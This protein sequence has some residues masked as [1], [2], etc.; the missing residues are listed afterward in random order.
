MIKRKHASASVLVFLQM[1]TVVSGTISIEEGF[2]EISR[3]WDWQ[4]LEYFPPMPLF[5]LT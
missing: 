2:S 5:M 3:D 1:F 4:E